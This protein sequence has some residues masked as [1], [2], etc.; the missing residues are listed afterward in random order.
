MCVCT[1]C[2]VNQVCWETIQ[3]ISQWS[4]ETILYSIEQRVCTKGFWISIA[5]AITYSPKITVTIFSIHTISSINGPLPVRSTVGIADKM[6]VYN[7]TSKTNRQFPNTVKEQTLQ[8]L[9]HSILWGLGRQQAYCQRTN[10]GRF[11][12]TA[13]YAMVQGDNK[14]IV[15]SCA[16][17][18]L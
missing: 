9:C 18:L 14:F 16:P 11:Y 5:K 2:H 17:N 8:G 12:V 15:K 13:A 7:F 1:W 10:S 4:S 3:S 6:L